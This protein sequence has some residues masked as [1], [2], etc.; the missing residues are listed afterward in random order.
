MALGA[1]PLRGQD[2]DTTSIE[3]D[4]TPSS[5]ARTAPKDSIVWLRAQNMAQL[6]G[7]M[8]D[9]PLHFA[10]MSAAEVEAPLTRSLR[11]LAGTVR[12]LAVRQGL[13]K[14]LFDA[15]WGKE[16]ELSVHPTKTG[17]AFLLMLDAGE[18]ESLVQDFVDR[19]ET[20]DR[21]STTRRISH[22]FG[23]TG[24]AFVGFAGTKLLIS[25]DRTTLQNTIDRAVRNA[26]P[27]SE[28]DE[29]SLAADPTFIAASIDSDRRAW[30]QV[31][32]RG[33]QTWVYD[34]LQGCGVLPRFVAN[35]VRQRTQAISFELRNESGFLATSLRFVGDGNPVLPFLTNKRPDPRLAR[36]I[37]P[38][39]MQW[40]AIGYEPSLMLDMLLASG[41][42]FDGLGLMEVLDK[43]IAAV[44]PGKSA[45]DIAASLAPSLLSLTADS[46]HP[47]LEGTVLLIED[48]TV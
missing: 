5:R 19:L 45:R 23:D 21:T 25:N 36:M 37:P 20:V 31:F 11:D 48:N 1:V 18:H 41:T 33:T 39:Q 16:V 9:H 12:D 29:S 44:L 8:A 42:A 15:L 17:Q 6:T 38:D 4:P 2:P 32:V 43:D 28:A 30:F 35:S 34:A 13:E 14:R 7:M 46:T 26:D 22:P 10:W 24:E 27:G 3:V 47:D 40:V